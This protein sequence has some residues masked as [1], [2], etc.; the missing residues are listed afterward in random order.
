VLGWPLL[1]IALLGLAENMFN[2]RAR[3]ARKRASR[4]LTN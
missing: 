2:I 3:I 4:T 1:L